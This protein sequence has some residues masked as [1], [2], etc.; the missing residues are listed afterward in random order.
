MGRSIVIPEALLPE[1]T[2]VMDRPKLPQGNSTPVYMMNPEQ[3]AKF[4]LQEAMER[5]A[6]AQYWME[7]SASN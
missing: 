5:L 1:V 3:K 2:V 4:Y 7:K 6:L